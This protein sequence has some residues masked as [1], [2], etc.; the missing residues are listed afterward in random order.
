M[1]AGDC[2]STALFLVYATGSIFLKCLVSISASETDLA[3]HSDRKSFRELHTVLFTN[4]DI[5]LHYRRLDA[6]AA[7]AYT[8]ETEASQGLASDT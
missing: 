2:H 4:N 6:S 8:K 3:L 1:S 7:M 5:Y